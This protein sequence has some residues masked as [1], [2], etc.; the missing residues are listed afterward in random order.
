MAD[1][2]TDEELDP[3]DPYLRPTQSFPELGET[4]AARISAY[5]SSE[6]VPQ[7]TVLF[8]R[9]QR[10]I[11]FFLI[12]D[13]AIEIVEYDEHHL[14]KIL[15][16]L[17][18][19]AFTGE[20]HLLN[21]RAVLVNGRTAIDSHLVRIK[22]QDFKRLMTAEPDIGEVILR[23]FI[24]RRV[25]FMRHAQGGVVVI[26]PGHGGD[27]LRIQRFLS[28]NGY[29]F[30]LVDVELDTHA[31][32]LLGDISAGQLPAVLSPDQSALFNPSNA[33]LADYL[34]LTEAWDPLR[35][36]D[37]AVLGAGPAGLAAAVYGASEGLDTIVIES[38]AP[39]GQ[40]GTSSKI[41][42]YLGF[43]TGI[44]GTALAGRAQV[45]AQKFGARLA[46][47]QTVVGIDCETY[48]YRVRLESGQTFL[49]KAVVVATGARYRKL[50]VA[51]FERFETQGLHF[52]A[53]AMEQKLCATNEVIVVGGGNSAGQAAIFLSQTVA[54]LHLLIRGDDLSATMSDYLIQRIRV[55][56]KITVHTRCEITA[57]E[58]ETALQKVTWT[59][60]NTGEQQTKLIGNVF[61]MIGAEPNTDWLQGCLA[62]DRSGF[63]KTG[64]DAHGQLLPSPFA[65]TLPGIYAIG[66]VRSGSVKRIAS[67]VGEGSVVIQAAHQFLHPSVG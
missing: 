12:L 25:G 33:Q 66:D 13:G 64:Y 32:D 46:I 10:H 36:Y 58:G 52:A 19:G 11:D 48:P 50:N 54:H 39:G 34:G 7:G 31:V 49:T 5:G 62:L 47:A 60:L 9:G 42:N 23:A 38:N 2:N 63:I 15:R 14:P 53:T 6:R 59:C 56:P 8:E 29:P 20:T 3:T 35:V 30:R 4:M 51:N 61:V 26:G 41:E 44:S 37:I 28:R 65:T 40:A 24:L 57:L 17:H 43:P 22:R 1:S 27:T 45:Q 67:S 16:V 21:G 55:S 18:K